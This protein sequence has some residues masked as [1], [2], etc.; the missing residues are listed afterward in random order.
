LI[1]IKKEYETNKNFNKNKLKINIKNLLFAAS[2][3]NDKM[4]EIFN[5][6][7]K[8]NE[9]LEIFEEITDFN[10][11]KK[12]LINSILRNYKE[13]VLPENDIFSYLLFSKKIIEIL[14][15]SNNNNEINDILS[16]FKNGEM[17][18]NLLEYLKN[19]DYN[20]NIYREN[21]LNIENNSIED[22]DKSYRSKINNNFENNS[23]YKE[24]KFNEKN[25]DNCE[26]ENNNIN[27]NIDSNK[28][29]EDRK[30]TDVN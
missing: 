14:I 12:I 17:K 30:Y 16:N 23:N 8:D 2:C 9:L 29:I 19:K 21:N 13:N 6:I 11:I 15:D 25:L 27:I 26:K 22:F 4:R 5:L 10:F 7:F 3:G 24:R 20:N 28:N 1:L 18:I